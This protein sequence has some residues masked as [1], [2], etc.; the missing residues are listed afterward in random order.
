MI[1]SIANI[2]VCTQSKT[3]TVPSSNLPKD[4][5][6]EERIEVTSINLTVAAE[7]DMYKI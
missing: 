6:E 2:S 5:N 4:K 1:K 7:R 3:C